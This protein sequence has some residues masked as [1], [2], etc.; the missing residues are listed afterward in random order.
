MKT[1]VCFRCKKRKSISKFRKYRN[2]SKTYRL[3]C[4]PCESFLK[5]ELYHNDPEVRRRQIKCSAAWTS[6]NM[7]KHVQYVNKYRN[8][9]L[10]SL[11]KRLRDRYKND[12]AYRER[13]LLSCRKYREKLN[14]QLTK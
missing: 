8:K 5:K 2:N 4:I 1:K 13:R 6:K 7:D 9:D 14:K 10:E 12:P 3:R 11:N